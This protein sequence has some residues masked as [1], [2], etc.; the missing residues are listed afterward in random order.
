MTKIRTD[1]EALTELRKLLVTEKPHVK[2]ANAHV[3]SHHSFSVFGPP[4]DVVAAARAEGVGILGLNDFFTTAGA[5]AF[6][7]ACAVA[8]LPGFLCVE[9]IARDE[10]AADQGVLL[11]DPG[12]PGKVYLCAKAV[13][14]PDHAQANARLAALRQQQEKRNRALIAALDVH[15]QAKLGVAGPTWDQVTAQTPAGNTTERHVAKAALLRL[16]ELT[17]NGRDFAADFAQLTGTD[18]KEGDAARQDQLRSALLKSGKP[19]YVAEDPAAFPTVPALRQV[20]LDLGAIPTY[21]IL[22]NPVTSGESDIP[23]LFDRIAAWGFHAV[24]VISP[25]NTDERLIA[26]LAEAAK[27]GWPVTDGTEHNTPVRDPLIT[28]AAVDPRFAAQFQAGALCVLGHAAERAAGRPGYVHPD[29]A[30]VSG[31][32]DCCVRAGSQLLAPPPLL[33]QDSDP[34]RCRSH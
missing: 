6:A 5:A 17:A 2:A 30:P 4:A 23:A 34:E 12:N 8:K 7:E 3:H 10:D 13:T 11:N 25:R 9:C 21:P 31:G 14:A 24:E 1:H 28:R 18:A 27:R 19:C 16:Q 20:F 22:G 33:P 29:G 32:Y 15:F 26:I